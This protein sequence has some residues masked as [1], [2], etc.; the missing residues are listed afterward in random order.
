MSNLA[1]S[2]RDDSMCLINLNRIDY[3][4]ILQTEFKYNIFYFKR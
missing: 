3:D 1:T 2:E 4:I